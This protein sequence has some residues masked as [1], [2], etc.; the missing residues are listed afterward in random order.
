MRRLAAGIL[1]LLV[2]SSSLLAQTKGEVES[3]GFGSFYRP[4]CFVPMLLRVQAEKSGTYQIRVIQEDM[5]RDRQIFTQTVS[6]TGSD[7]GKAIEQKFWTYFIPQPGDGGLVDTTRGG[8]LRDLQQQ[9]KVILCDEKGKEVAQLAVTA[10][11]SG[12]ITNIDG[13]QTGAYP[14]GLRSS[15]LILAVTDGAAQPVW[16]DYQQAIGSVEDVTFVTVRS[17]DLPEDVRG[18]EMIDGIVW[19]A[20]PL[21]DPAKPADEKRYH[22]IQAYVRGGGHLVVCQPARRDDTLSVAEMLPVEVVEIAPRPDLEPLKTIATERQKR[23]EEAERSS[24]PLRSNFNALPEDEVTTKRRSEDWLIPQGPFMFARATPK[25]GAIVEED[26]LKWPDGTESPYI[27]RIGYGLG[28]VTWVAHDLS[29]PVFTNRAKSGWPYVW[30][31]VLDYKNDLIVVSNRTTED[32]KKPYAQTASADLGRPLLA[33]MELS[34]KSAALVS[35]A[36]VFFIGYWLVAGPGVYFYLAAKSKAQLSWFFFA[37]SAVIATFFTVLVVKLVVRGPPELA[38][39]TVVRGAAGTPQIS[40]AR[41]GLYIPRDGAQEIAIPEVAP[42]N[43][44]YITAYP[45]HPKHGGG[46]IEF[47]AQADYL[48]PIHDSTEEGPVTI[49]VPF[50]STEK[51]FAARRVGEA[52]GGIEGSAKLRQEYDWKLEGLLTNGTGR[53][54]RDVYFIYH[55]PGEIDDQVLYQPTWEA[56]QTINLNDFN[57][58]R[59]TKL[60]GNDSNTSATPDTKPKVRITGRVGNPGTTFGWS[61]YWYRS[62]QISSKGFASEQPYGDFDKAMIMMSIFN[63]LPPSRNSQSPKAEH[64]DMLR[65]GG[66]YLDMSNAIAAGKLVVLATADDGTPSPL[67]FPL[68][69]DGEKVAGKGTVFYQY[70]LPIERI[71]ES[72][73]TKPSTQQSATTQPTAHVT[74]EP[75]WLR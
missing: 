64:I 38:H 6:L 74:L 41:F 12:T 61:E 71:P 72:S 51:L 42:R 5:D 36:V 57:D 24:T 26:K 50:R 13:Y 7:E 55:R 49:S 25:P 21:P 37:L 69:V 4:N 23:M 59:N 8:N 35:I 46:D 53:R 62:F 54:L 14:A 34:S 22:A 3:I 39:I 75:A 65:R 10:Q 1:F 28:C 18:Y 60:I 58:L 45:K 56:A 16:R 27:A 40:L 70:A 17:T 44:S 33:P 20:A 19:L 47:P 67:P 2:F 68:T 9:L 11:G 73:T 66:R 48:V 43:V 15:K 31:R 29:D 32:M 63:R 52:G 30:D